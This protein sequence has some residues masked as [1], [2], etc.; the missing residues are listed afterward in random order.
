M[1]PE[2][3]QSITPNT[4]SVYCV[5]SMRRNLLPHPI[6]QPLVRTEQH[7]PYSDNSAEDSSPERSL[8]AKRNTFHN[9][10]T[11]AF[12]LF[13]QNQQQQQ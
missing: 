8:S 9:F 11:S 2:W 10:S 4:R 6:K 1:T 7:V 12:V 5:C 3:S 13:F